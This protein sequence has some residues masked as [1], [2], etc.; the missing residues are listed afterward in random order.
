M[1]TPVAFLLNRPVSTF[2][3]FLNGVMGSSVLLSSMLAP[4]PRAHQWSGLTPHAQN[5][6]ANRCGKAAGVPPMTGCVPQTGIDANH[7]K[8]MAQPTPRRK[9][10]REMGNGVGAGAWFGVLIVYL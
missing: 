7:G 3:L 8:A 9:V 6:V 2:I 5:S 10:R 1:P 4:A